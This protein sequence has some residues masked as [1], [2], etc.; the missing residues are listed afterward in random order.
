MKKIL[1]LF[2]S[3]FL[4]LQL[5]N[6][7][8]IV[9]GSENFDGN[10]ISFNVTSAVGATWAADTA[11]YVSSPKAYLGNVPTSLGDSIILT[12]PIYDFTSYE[13]VHL[14]FSQICKVSACDIARVEYR[15]DALGNQGAW[16]PIPVNSYQGAGVYSTNGF[17]A[18]SYSD[19]QG[20][21]S[22]AV[23]TAAW[24]KQESFDLTNQVGF[25]RA[26][27][28]FVLKRGNVVGTQ[29]SY[30][31]LLDDVIISASSF[32]IKPPTVEFVSP[33]YRDT[34]YATGPYDIT[35][36]VKSNTNARINVPVLHFTHT[37]NNVSVND[38]L[39]M[40]NI[41][42]DTLW[43]A[44]IPQYIFGTDVVY[45]VT[46]SDTVGNS[47]TI[48]S[49]YFIKHPTAGGFSGYT[50]CGDTTT[51]LTESVAPFNTNYDYGWSRTLYLGSE[52]SPVG[53]T[54]T[55][56][57]FK[58]QSYTRPTVLQNQT[59]YFQLVND[60]SIS[61]ANYWDPVKEGATL[62]WS[63]SI[64]VQTGYNWMNIHLTTPFVIP[65]GSNLLV[66]WEN[67]DGAYTGMAY[68]YYTSVTN[69]SVSTYQDGSFP[70]SAGRINSN[71]PVA[72][73]ALMGGATDS[74]SVAM[75]KITT[76][77][78]LDIHSG[79]ANPV[80]VVIKNKGLKNLT[81][82][83]I[84]W[85][86][87][88]VSQGDTLW[89][90]N[91]PEDF[92]DTIV[93]GS[94]IPTANGYD[95]I[96]VWVNTPNGVYDSTTYDDT[97]STILFGCAGPMAGVYNVGIGT[98]Y[99]TIS[100]ALYL[101]KTCGASADVT[102]ALT[103]GTYTGTWDFTGFGSTM[104]NYHLTVTSAAHNA[105]SVILRPASAQSGV[106]LNNTKNLTISYIT[107]DAKTNSAYHGVYFT[108]LCENVNI[109]Y[110]KILSL[111]T[112]TSSSYYGIRKASGTGVL[113]NCRIN[114][115]EV[116]GGYY[117]VYLYGASQTQRNTVT[118]DSNIL[119]N[120]YYY[121]LYT[122]YNNYKVH[123]NTITSRS[124][125]A[126]TA[127]YGIHS[128][129]N[130]GEITNN[131]VRALKSFTTLYCAYIY[132]TGDTLN[133]AL[134]AN[135]EIYA[136]TSSSYYGVYFYASYVDVINNSVYATGS[137]ARALYFS[138]TTNNY[139]NVRNN[140]CHTVGTSSY[141]IYFSST[142]YLNAP[143]TYVDY[144]DYYST[145]T[146]IAY[147]GGAKTTLAAI[148]AVLTTDVHSVKIAPQYTDV[149]TSAAL[150]SFAG[151][152]C[153][154]YGNIVYDIDGKQRLFSTNMGAYGKNPSS[155][156]AALVEFMG[157]SADSIAGNTPTVSVVVG[158]AGLNTIT[159]LNIGWKFNGVSQPNVS[160][161]GNLASG[162]TI[163]V[164]L[165]AIT[166][167][168]GYN[169]MEAYVRQ[170]NSG[171]DSCNTNDTLIVT[172]YICSGP[173]SGTVTVGRGGT[174]ASINEALSTIDLCGA[175]GSVTISIQPGT[176]VETLDLL[177]PIKGMTSQDTLIFES[178]T[179]NYANVV[180]Q[181]DGDAKTDKGVLNLGIDNVAFRNITLYS[182]TVSGGAYTYA[183]CVN[184][185]NNCNNIEFTG[186]RL[187]NIY[188]FSS[189]VT[190]PTQF[191]SFYNNGFTMNNLRMVNN[192]IMGS[193]C[194]F[195]FLGNGS[196]N[197]RFDSNMVL[198][199]DMYNV[200]ATNTSFSSFKGNVAEQRDASFI[201]PIAFIPY[202]FENV[203]GDII[204]NRAYAVHGLEGIHLSNFNS[205]GSGKVINNEIKLTGGKGISIS[206]NV[207]AEVVHNSI[208]IDG[209]TL[210]FGIFV[211][212]AT[213]N[214]TIERNN[215]ITKTST[216]DYPIYIAN[217]SAVSGMTIDYNNY[218]S[219]TGAYVG[220][221]GNAKSSMSA[222]QAAT[223]QDAHSVIAMPMFLNEANSLDL[224]DSIGISCPTLTSVPYDIK[225]N[226]RSTTTCMGAYHV[227]Q[228]AIDMTL[229]AIT[230]PQDVVTVGDSVDVKVKLYNSGSSA[231][232]SAIISWEL[233]GVQQMPY[234]WSGSLSPRATSSEITIG[235]FI[236]QKGNAVIKVYVSNPNNSIDQNP[237]N[238]TLSKDVYGCA[239][240]MKGTYV[241]SALDD[242]DFVS[243]TDAIKAMQTCGIDSAVRIEIASDASQQFS[244]TAPVP[245]ASATNNITIT[246]QGNAKDVIYV[247]AYIGDIKHVTFNNMGFDATANYRLVDV[248]APCEDIEFSDCFMVGD[249]ADPTTGVAAVAAIS[250][251][252]GNG[253]VK[254]FRVLRNI[255]MGGTYSLYFYGSATDSCE[256]IIKDNIMSDFYTYGIYNYYTKSEIANNTII[257]N[258]YKLSNTSI[259]PIYAYYS[260]VNVDNN[261]IEINT[262]ELSYNYGIYT[263]Y[264]TIRLNHNKTVCKVKDLNYYYG[265]YAYYAP[266]SY[267]N[268]N[269]LYMS[270]T[271]TYA[272]GIYHYY[273]SGHNTIT[274]NEL[275]I[276]YSGNSSYYAMYCYAY[277]TTGTFDIHHNSIRM[278]SGTGNYGYG[279]Y[280][281]LYGSAA[282][283]SIRNNNIEMLTSGAYP[284]YLNQSAASYFGVGQGM[285]DI[286]YNNLVAPTYVGYA[287][288]AKATI[289]AWQTTVK[290]DLH[291][292][293][294]APVYLSATCD[295]L[296]VA[297]DTAYICPSVAVVNT[298]IQGLPR[299][300]NT[301]MGAYGSDPSALDGAL[302]DIVDIPATATKGTVVSPKIVLINAGSAPLT[303]AVINWSFNGVQQTAINWSGN[304]ALLA[305]DTISSSN[306]TFVTGNNEIKAWLTSVNNTVDSIPQNDTVS[307]KIYACDSML[308][309]NYTVGPNGDIATID[310][311]NELL[312]NC[313][314]GG[315]VVFGFEEGTHMGNLNLSQNI[316]GADTYSMH[317]TK[318][319]MTGNPAIIKA[320]SGS[321]VMLGKNS[322]I[323][324]D[325]LTID[326]TTADVAI[327]FIT[328]CSN[329][330]ITNCNILA[331]PNATSS[332][333]YA[334]HKPSNSG[335]LTNF[336]L[337]NSYVSGGY[338][339]VYLY[340]GTGTSAFG[341][342]YIDSNIITNQYYYGNYYYYT[343]LS[344][345]YNEV[346]T[347]S[348]AS[349][350]WYGI[351]M[352]YVN[353]QITCNR[354]LSMNRI[355]SGGYGMYSYYANVY[356]SRGDVH[357]INNEIHM[358]STGSN[359]G[360][361]F[362]YANSLYILHNS[363]YGQATGGARGIYVGQSTSYTNM[364]I[365]NNNI[366]ITGTSTT[367]YPMYIATTTYCM[368]PYMTIDYNNYYHNTNIGYAGGAKTTLSAWQAVTQQ[369]VNSVK[370]NPS[371]VDS[372][373]NLALNDA[374]GL[375]CYREGKVPYDIE[376]VKREYLTPMGAYTMHLFTGTDLALTEIVEPTNSTS[377]CAPN[378]VSVKYAVSNAGGMAVDFSVTPL[379]LTI[380]IDGAD[381]ATVDTLI[382]TGSLDV[383]ATDTFE[384]TNMLNVG[385]AGNYYL[386][387]YLSTQNDSIH[388]ND[389]LTGMYYTHKIGLP[390][391]EDFD[392][393]NMTDLTVE[394]LAGANVWHVERGVSGYIDPV[395]GLGK[396]AFE[397]TL[398]SVGRLSTAQ[399][400]LNRTAQPTL[401]FWYAHDT[402]NANLNDQM[403]VK[404]T[405]DGGYTH[406]PLMNLKRYNAN[407]SAPAWV[408]YTID[409]SPYV[410]SACAILV[411]EAQSYG[412]PGQYLDRIVISSNSNVALTDVMPVGVS[413][414]GLTNKTLGVE[415]TN[416]TGQAIDF[417]SNRTSIV[418][419][420]SGATNQTLTY[421]LLSGIVYGL[422]VDTIAV[423]NNFDFVPGTYNVKAYISPAI[424]R[425]LDDDT[426]YA[427]FT[428]NPKLNVEAQQITGGNEA[429]N[430]IE[431]G[432]KV[433]QVVT[434]TNEGN[435]D[436]EDLDLVMNIY[437]INGVLINSVYDT[438]SGMFAVNNS[439]VKTFSTAYT[440]PSD[441]MYNVE[442]IASPA[443]NAAL[444]FTDVITEC[445]DQN[446]IAVTAILSPVNG[447]KQ[448][449]SAKVK[450]RVSNMNPNEDKAGIVLHAIVSKVD[451]T[452]IVNW[453]ETLNEISADSYLDFEFPQSF[454]IPSEY[455]F[456]VKAFVN[457]VDANAVNDT[458]QAEIQTNVGVHESNADGISMSQNIPNPANNQTTVSYSVPNDG[459]V[460]FTIL[461]VAG[462]IL[463][464]QTVKASA[465][466]NSID[467]N[468]EHLAAG[469]YFYTMDFQGQRLM[470]K[471]VIRK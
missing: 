140:I 207:R 405:F 301:I 29:F 390:Y 219:K 464:T 461:N 55:D 54:I 235:S 172:D 411:F 459:N 13:F 44:T 383:F 349:T 188:S 455:S 179:G 153:P 311:L 463:H 97:V 108:G 313:G 163:H 249:T 391:D 148:S 467:F 136:N 15:L 132:Y 65:A 146:N 168:S 192:I 471:M 160:W 197:V 12:T 366:V 318:A 83:K 287:G 52:I 101:L 397:G 458:L 386:T 80:T 208:Y 211:S 310:D 404:I 38:S 380:R 395:F 329:I 115:N 229:A 364:V 362:Y 449:T 166:Y 296:K 9:V 425:T 230:A 335:V 98:S 155:I 277:N 420:I 85:S 454:T 359:S 231:L 14:T 164:T 291:S 280:A 384:V 295:S 225:G 152:D 421:N 412:G 78:Q 347:S 432:S 104:G 86:I 443:C 324:F 162:D 282:S 345:N 139:Y 271:A 215:I 72:R 206:D 308:Q 113:T 223:G 123:A 451:G 77:T 220:Y 426:V 142:T 158:N 355:L 181:T 19:W 247:E 303:S 31:W 276:N 127:W 45:S 374:T 256:V 213:T 88:G 452:E 289:S 39:V 131:R 224:M 350:S 4:L 218:Y 21:D 67:N 171:K 36:K 214:S 331:Q 33:F 173:I 363:I 253:P 177:T 407:I 446:D 309:G 68:F 267:I 376:G 147:V 244:F 373:V 35:A 298:D 278:Y 64:P 240:M 427:T 186:C 243:L 371:F 300:G 393:Y 71:R 37:Y 368:P 185:K 255:I 453:T 30:G 261:Y 150:N 137:S 274:N 143:Y 382:S 24:W 387:A 268:G 202:Y 174:F 388:D 60:L 124:A 165:G 156:D 416:M 284:L 275:K 259:Y 402:S 111:P 306:V 61:D 134:F 358:K 189:V 260:N 6:A 315:N 106:V 440:V 109:S 17:N 110:N 122:Y 285:Y 340:G 190:Y 176:Y 338:Y 341:D 103:S 450:V 40:S 180:I 322:N 408:K 304:L 332:T 47:L 57:A 130:L 1:M 409:L 141:P 470:K 437:D 22:L 119:T 221:V 286:D 246:N 144:N 50:Y 199:C 389:T 334:I 403:D 401:E 20:Q 357:V 414:C 434:I 105:D 330:Y 342:L 201:V 151:L 107:I 161:T 462:Q 178:S 468:T 203:N 250:V 348:S 210:S 23:P 167:V 59:C 354:I 265:I 212:A 76:P 90:G 135:N 398:G 288:G 314:I 121:S 469:I 436:M 433:Y 79:I 415:V 2:C 245:G 294:V 429:T 170:V 281:Y 125:N 205:N 439:V 184:I 365:R 8:A 317:F 441:E 222:F 3:M 343:H 93:V 169:T 87:N 381:T 138:M 11:Y 239:P 91:L 238:D 312:Q 241:V 216:A 320:S 114:N 325:S 66:Y 118:I 69:G 5:A 396:L 41:S 53:G 299:Y 399:I 48:K 466:I 51:T 435:M 273:G 236:A 328:G 100:D 95:S 89:T 339:G 254:N 283:F 460:V 217:T 126:G 346:S 377:L 82:A 258:T 96:L 457:S 418:V 447:A 400:E 84:G 7:Q 352:Y 242:K 367:A 327:K 26:Q 62:V 410:D 356:S 302:V 81:S 133:H 112:T 333:K 58:L 419:E 27:F 198:Y 344:F 175:S 149:T 456:M 424:D 56:I 413:A 422:E 154:I 305:S 290:T 116:D 316:L 187:Y 73:F 262:K 257:K 227:M 251:Q 129:Y 445:V 195:Y 370:V 444:T 269:K 442:I 351:Y 272:Y 379:R 196:S 270:D 430:C 49:G 200:Y 75:H 337:R 264:S 183:K 145:G 319:N 32:E 378:Y 394:A 428:V 336:V 191:T 293:S 234:Q 25:D 237:E 326:A 70:T 94:Y 361:Y 28:R 292:V 46:G 157:W 263:Y 385:F 92:N 209:D 392:T 431:T 128:Y 182:G 43:R 232:S 448:T 438:I 360:M 375:M 266:Y 34:V 233:D 63:G 159:S 228:M 321:A 99:P 307:V 252:N 297:N 417:S 323:S 74:N 42:G 117:N 465:G 18:Y 193:A 369:D 248:I 406:V 353:P 102:F 10:T 16:M 194:G 120:A 372:S 204:A 279:I 226:S 423:T